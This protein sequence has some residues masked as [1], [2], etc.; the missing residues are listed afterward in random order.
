MRCQF[1]YH[2][3]IRIIK[4]ESLGV[5]AFQLL[6]RC[7]L[8]FTREPQ[9]VTAEC[10]WSGQRFGDFG[11]LGGIREMFVLEAVSGE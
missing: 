5:S 6:L 1:T 10:L 11:C 4:L 3:F 9:V 7:L 8:K 2:N